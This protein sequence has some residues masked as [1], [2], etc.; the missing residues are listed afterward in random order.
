MSVRLLHL[1]VLVLLIPVLSPQ[2]ADASTMPAFDYEQWRRDHPRPS[3]KRLADLNVGEPRTVRMIYF[4]P[5]DRAYQDGVVDSM[6]TMIRRLQGFYAE[7]MEAHGYGP[8]TFQYE[9]DDQGEPLVHRLDGQNPDSHYVDGTFDAVFPEIEQTFD[10][11]QNI[12]F[13]LIDNSIHEITEEDGSEAG[14][15]ARPVGKSG[16]VALFSDEF[17]FGIAA[18]ELTHAFGAVWHD[19]NSGAYVL[20]YGGNPDE[21]SLC[22][23]HFLSAHPYFNADADAETAPGPT[24]ELVSPRTYPTGSTT[25]SVQLSLGDADGLHQVYLLVVTGWLHGAA[26]FDEVKECRRLA[27]EEEALLEFEYDGST[28]SNVRTHLSNPLVHTI[29]VAAVDGDGNV[30]FLSFDLL[31]TS[32]QLLATLEGEGRYDYSVAFSPD[33]N[34]LAS[35]TQTGVELWGAETQNSLAFLPGS[36]PVAFAPDGTL[37]SAGGGRTVRLWDVES[38][39]NTGILTGHVEDVR[40]LAFAPG[41]ATLASGSLDGEVRLWDVATQTGRTIVEGSASVKSMAIS[42][43]GNVLAWTQNQVINLWDLEGGES[44][45]PLSGHA[46]KVFAVAFS[47]DGST[48]AS[49]SLDGAVKLWDVETREDRTTLEHPLAASVA[50]SPGGATLASGS[51][52]GTIRLWDLLNEQR[53]GALTGHTAAVLSLVFSP[54]GSTLASA[55]EDHTV[56]LWDASEWTGPRPVELLKISGV[57]QQAAPGE[58]L[59]DPFVVEVRDQHGNPLPGAEVTFAVTAGDGQLG[60]R[61]SIEKKKTD[62]NGRSESSVLTLGPGPGTNTVEA[63]AGPALVTF[64]SMGVGT[65]VLT[66]GGDHRTW[67]LPDGAIARLGKGRLSQAERAIALSPDGGKLAAVSSIGVWLY[68]VE[69]LQ[70]IAHFPTAENRFGSVVFSPDGTKVAASP[71]DQDPVTRIWDIATGEVVAEMEGHTASAAVFSP[72]GTQ[73]ASGLWDGT[74]K[75]WDL[76]TGAEVATLEGHGDGVSSVSFAPDGS[77]LASGS[78]DKS[79]KLWDLESR[80]EAATLEGHVDVVASVSFSPDGMT[81]ASGSWDGTLRLWDV[82]MRRNTAT[83]ER[84]AVFIES[85]SFSPDGTT[86]ASVSHKDIKLWDTATGTGTATLEGHRLSVNT[87]SFSADGTTLFSG[88]SADGTIWRWDVASGNATLLP[89]HFAEISSLAFSPDGSVL[90]SGT[91]SRT[92][93]LWD[94]ASRANAA[95]LEGY[96]GGANIA[97]SPDGATLASAWG[98]HG[99]LWDLATGRILATLKNHRGVVLSLGFTPDGRL[100]SAAADN[101]IALWDAEMG[102]NTDSFVL[103]GGLGEIWPSSSV[104]FSPGGSILAAGARDGTIKLWDAATGRN[105]AVLSGHDYTVFS[106]AFSPDGGTL[107][108]GSD[109]Q[110]LRLWEVATGA[111]IRTLSGQSRANSLSFSPDGTVLAAGLSGYEMN[112]VELWDL[113]T[114]TRI[115]SLLGHRSWVTALAFSPGGLICASGSLDGTV[116]LWD[117]RLIL[118]HARTLT[119]VS[120]DEQE[121]TSNA[122]LADSFVVEVRD[123]NGDLFEGAQVIFVLTAGDGFLSRATATTDARGRASTTLTLGE[124]LGAYTVQVTV[125]G[126]VAEVDPVTFTAAAKATPDFDGD[127]EV[128]FSDFFLFAEAFGGSDPR[129]D[130]DASGEVG[131]SDFFLFAE[132]FG[133]PQRAKLLALARERIGLPD[134]P[135]L[136]QNAPNPFNSGTVISWFLLQDGPARLEVYGL[137]GQRVAVLSRGPHKAG[138]YRFRWDGRDDQGRLLASG[139]YVYRLVTSRGVHTRKLTLLR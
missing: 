125:E 65:P 77:M 46:S 9:T 136:Q 7:Q 105:T 17:H 103:E 68:D 139:V 29:H 50:F 14:G 27:G 30:S 130:L 135:Q 113:A 11:S 128:G 36:G 24:I 124:D 1:T 120:G 133:Q 8:R 6:K 84:T 98:F 42:P 10:V 127:G 108:S 88:S 59:A 134:G 132:S 55:S 21:L 131:F 126:T 20:S 13:V 129:F 47:P 43:D 95:S 96:G 106:L 111:R 54:D 28:P 100:V 72:D 75:L 16:G 74:I 115:A 81:L 69:T 107:A 35:G 82:P 3:A 116:L 15:A 49:A 39:G 25:V 22:S 122:E 89:G 73:L 118:P 112:P 5:N 33:G 76:A 18:H 123:Q 138:L 91:S 40:S 79:I 109:D 86:L 87:V 37:A 2:A 70:P 23:A 12:Y 45:A 61:F 64:S 85:L 63:S 137:T 56:K 94:T 92:I 83:L 110:D 71:E 31:A 66:A 99:R 51:V 58:D 34:T 93:Q 67:H 41:G 57:N 90:A 53:L 4:L 48:L 78:W 26:G 52:D 104:W 97:F 38:S 102:T 44:I 62:A 32:P 80:T 114:G 121:A 19:F 119:K 101:R 60:G 117:V